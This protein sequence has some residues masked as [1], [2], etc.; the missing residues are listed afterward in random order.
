MYFTDKNGIRRKDQRVSEWETECLQ[1]IKFQYKLKP[2]GKV[3]Q[4]SLW[5][6]FSNYRKN[7]IDNRLK[8]TLDLLEKA[9]IYTDDANLNDIDIH[10]RYDHGN[11]RLEIEF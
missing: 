7:D 8:C 2:T 4:V 5:Y 6:F 11:P 1:I 3:L 9:G 10:K